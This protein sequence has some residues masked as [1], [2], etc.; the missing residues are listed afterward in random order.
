M[1]DQMKSEDVQKEMDLAFGARSLN[2]RRGSIS[3]SMRPPSPPDLEPVKIRKKDNKRVNEL[4]QK[5]GSSSPL[6]RRQSSYVGASTM[7]HLLALTQFSM[8]DLAKLRTRFHEI[9]RHTTISPEDFRHALGIVGMTSDSIISQRLFAVFDESNSGQLSFA[10]YARGLSIM[11]KGTIEEKL[12]LSFQIMD[13]NKSGS[14]SFN[15]F[16]AII[17]STARTYCGIMGESMKKGTLPESEVRI[18]FDVFDKDP[19]TGEVTRE[20]YIKGI[21]EHPRLLSNFGVNRKRSAELTRLQIE[22]SRL[23]DHLSRY[24]Q[25]LAEVMGKME[26]F[27]KKLRGV[28]SLSEKKEEMLESGKML[29]QEMGSWMREILTVTSSRHSTSKYRERMFSS[30]SK[31]SDDDENN[32]GAGDSEEKEE[33]VEGDDRATSYY[34]DFQ[35]KDLG[36]AILNGRV[37]RC[38]GKESDKI[39]IGDEILRVGEIAVGEVGKNLDARIAKMI[40]RDSKRPIRITFQRRRSLNSMKFASAEKMTM[41]RNRLLNKSSG[42]MV[43]FGHRDWELVMKLMQ[44]IQLSVN[45]ANQEV[46]RD[47]TAH[48]FNVKEKYVVFERGGVRAPSARISIIFTS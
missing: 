8:T 18:M 40:G 24:K 13:L 32:S 23:T 36:L 42:N 29:D 34:V 21:M 14:I 35:E 4:R 48:D 22:R 7:T 5:G 39:N 10:N 41:L 6:P 38:S 46:E 15:E 30:T 44:G 28:M 11:M 27:R 45:R 33:D 1:N 9:S 17:Q 3:P 25:T 20:L 37:T 19:K 47:V 31:K 16:N 12:N 2:G 26:H 43:F